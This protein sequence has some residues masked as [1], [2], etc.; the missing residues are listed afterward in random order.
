MVRRALGMLLLAVVAAWARGLAA[1]LTMEGDHAAYWRRRSRSPGTVT[2]V[3]LGDSLAQG[4]GAIH[5]ER[6]WAGRLAEE[7][8]ARTGSRVKVLVL[9]VCGAGVADVLRDQL[10]R[11][12]EAALR[13]EPGTLVALEVGTNDASGG[14]DPEEYRRLLTE[15]CDA[16]PAGSLVGDVPDLQRRWVRPAGVR[17]AAVAREV[18]AAQPGLRLVRVEAAT[19]RMAPWEFG[20]D[21]A[22]PNGLGYRRFGRAFTAALGG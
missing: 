18:V 4:L 1:A 14:T 16:L 12:P 3:A 13:G 9:G 5:P 17:L 8:Q 7:I 19:H 10:P 2:L 21:L 15:L 11:V 20:P 6:S 22:H